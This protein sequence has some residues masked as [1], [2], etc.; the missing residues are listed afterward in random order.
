M[1]EKGGLMLGWV[2]RLDLS[3]ILFGEISCINSESESRSVVS[4]CL[5]PHGPYSSW[6]SSG[7]DIG[8]G[9]ISLLWEIL[10]TQ[11]SNPGLPHLRWI[12]YC[13][14]HR[15][16]PRIVEWVAYPFFRGRPDPGIEPRSPALQVDSLPN[17]LPGKPLPTETGPCLALLIGRG[18]DAKQISRY[19][20]QCF[21]EVL[22]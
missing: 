2:G 11:G 22:F 13:L 10:P 6:N 21:S 3:F 4:Y 18:K 19:P 5:R 15:G 12:L 7:Q 16:S 14:S 20:L 8:L 9:S 1:K 17:E